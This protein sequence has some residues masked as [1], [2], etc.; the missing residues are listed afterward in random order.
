MTICPKDCR[1][2]T[3]TCHCT[4]KTYIE[5]KAKYEDAKKK[6]NEGRDADRYIGN[7]K[8]RRKASYLKRKN[9]AK[10]GG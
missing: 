9:K 2:R 4:C 6:L 5:N 3:E 8:S 7:N 1:F 10:I